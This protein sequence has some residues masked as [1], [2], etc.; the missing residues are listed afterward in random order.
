[1]FRNN[2]QKSAF[3]ILKVEK[4]LLKRTAVP[5]RGGTL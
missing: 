3:K 2:L 5:V 1:M 4:E